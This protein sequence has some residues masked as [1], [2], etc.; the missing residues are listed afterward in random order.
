MYIDRAPL[1]EQILVCHSLYSAEI[2]LGDFIDIAISMSAV[3]KT[4]C[5]LY[6]A[7]SRSSSNWR[8]LLLHFTTPWVSSYDDRLPALHPR[9]PVYEARPP[10][11]S[12]HLTRY[13]LFI[14]FW[15]FWAT[16]GYPDRTYRQVQQGQNPRW[17]ACERVRKLKPQPKPAF[18]EV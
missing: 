8:P 9:L 18:G 1:S 5:H 6:M 7:L 17:A 15:V 2:V 11:R 12:S 3:L 14:Y 10:S 13:V 16:R 4:D